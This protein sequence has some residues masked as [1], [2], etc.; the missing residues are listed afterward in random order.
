MWGHS[1]SCSVGIHGT[2][3]F[4]ACSGAINLSNQLLLAAEPS[5]PTQLHPRPPAQDLR[6]WAVDTLHTGQQGRELGFAESRHE[7][8]KGSQWG[9]SQARTLLRT[10]P[11]S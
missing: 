4:L 7:G 8:L 10:S 6:V 3:G 5:H 11:D 9:H 1:P 2:T